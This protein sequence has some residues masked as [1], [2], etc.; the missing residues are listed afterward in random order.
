MA[1]KKTQKRIQKGLRN[2]CSNC[3]GIRQGNRES[4]AIAYRNCYKSILRNLEFKGAREPELQ[5][6]FYEA[7]EFAINRI[8][9]GSIDCNKLPDD[10]FG[11]YIYIIAYRNYLNWRGKTEKEIQTISL[12]FLLE[13]G[14]EPE[15]VDHIQEIKEEEEK[16]RKIELALKCLN[17]T[18]QKLIRLRIFEA[19]SFREIALAI[20]YLKPDRKPNADK[21]RVYYH[22]AMDRLKELTIGNKSRLIV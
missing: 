15:L 2:K 3:L 22:R 7:F 5:E 13:N 6:F 14:F 4:W 8:E 21:A 1:Q 18:E 20:E 17:H 12:D 10:K 16:L 11:G 19:K 9:K